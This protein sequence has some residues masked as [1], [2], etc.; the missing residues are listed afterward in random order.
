MSKHTGKR[1]GNVSKN[2]SWGGRVKATFRSIGNW[3]LRLGG[4]KPVRTG[5]GRKPKGTSGRAGGST[6]R[7][8]ASRGRGG[9]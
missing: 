2:A 1:S 4:R 6:S 5:R 3:L 8:M 9:R 7:R